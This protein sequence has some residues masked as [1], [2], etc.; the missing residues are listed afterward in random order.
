MLLL[1]SSAWMMGIGL[2][3]VMM[4]PTDLYT[5]SWLDKFFDW[6]VLLM[7]GV[8]LFLV[9]VHGYFKDKKEAG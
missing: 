4:Q 7:L 1:L 9:T 5:F 8:V 3:F 2:R 6:G